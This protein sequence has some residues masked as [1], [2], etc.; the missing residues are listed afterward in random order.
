MRLD[1]LLLICVVCSTKQTLHP[2]TWALDSIMSGITHLQVTFAR[3]KYK[4][5]VGKVMGTFM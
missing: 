1:V 2:I 5:D 3:Q 4:D